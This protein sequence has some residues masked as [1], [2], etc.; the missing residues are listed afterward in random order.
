[1]ELPQRRNGDKEAEQPK[2]P[3][4]QDWRLQFDTPASRW[5]GEGKTKPAQEW[6]Q[7]E[8]A[9]AARQLWGQA[10]SALRGCSEEKLTAMDNAFA[11][12]VDDQ[13]LEVTGRNR[14]LSKGDV[15]E[16]QDFMIRV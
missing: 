11:A 10:S 7:T 5:G 16:L 13:L 6:S 1:M 3:E 14:R 9:V 4:V 8:G 12:F 2:N 15:K